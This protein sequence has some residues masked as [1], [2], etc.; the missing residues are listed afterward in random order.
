MK[1][2]TTEGA[3]SPTIKWLQWK[4]SSSWTTSPQA[5]GQCLSSGKWRPPQLLDVWRNDRGSRDDA[6]CWQ[7]IVFP[8]QIICV[9]TTAG[10]TLGVPDRRATWIALSTLCAYIQRKIERRSNTNDHH[11]D[12]VRNARHRQGYLFHH[13]KLGLT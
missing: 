1:T 7:L 12:R 9:A 5:L 4:R 13:G 2:L 10:S 3:R 6:N 11:E 8:G